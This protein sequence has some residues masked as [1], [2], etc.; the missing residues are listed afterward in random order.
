MRVD[1]ILIISTVILCILLTITDFSKMLLHI[2]LQKLCHE[3]LQY[4]YYVHSEKEKYNIITK[5]TTNSE[6]KIKPRI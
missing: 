4:I 5:T 2:Y 1:I 6:V 3:A